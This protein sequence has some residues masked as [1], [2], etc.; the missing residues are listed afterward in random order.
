M[1][2]QELAWSWL[3]HAAVL[4]AVILGAGCLV[5]CLCGEPVKRIRLIQ[6][7]FLAGVLAVLLTP[8]SIW[9]RWSLGLW[10]SVS[11]QPA[12]VPVEVFHEAEA[13]PSPIPHSQDRPSP[14]DKSATTATKDPPRNVETVS[15]VETFAGPEV[16]DESRP[17]PAEGERVW[18]WSIPWARLAV[19]GYLT[20]AAALLCWW[21]L[22]VLRMVWLNRSTQPA[23]RW[24]AE[25]LRAIAGDGGARVR[26]RCGD[27]V[28]SPMV[29]GG[30]RPV[31]L[32]PQYLCDGGN[33][34]ELRF[35]LAHEW[36]HIENRDVWSWQLASFVAFLFY[37]QPAYWWLRRQLRLC[38]DYLAD[39]RAA[40]Q[41]PVP[42][43]YAEF[44]VG[45]AR[46]R[47]SVPAAALGIGDGRSNLYRRVVMLL[48]TRKA[49]A[50]GCHWGWNLGVALSALALLA[51]LSTVRLDAADEAHQAVRDSDKPKESSADGA[52]IK[53][54][55]YTGKVSDKDTG[56]PIEGAMVVVRRS[57]Y[58][59]GMENKIMQESKHTT[60]KDG[61]Y[62]FT[63]PP[64]QV[65]ERS[66]YIELDVE[67]PDY[68][69]Q[70]NFGY[71]L[72]M[73]LKDEKLGGRPFFE[74]VELRPGKAVT[75]RLE[76]PDGKPAVGVK[77]LSY[78]I[79]DKTQE[80]VFEYG[81]FADTKTNEKGEFRV[82]MVTP[83]DAVLW[84]LPA[85]GYVPST[86]VVGAK[87]GDLG[88][89]GLKDGIRIKGTV[90]DAQGKPLAGISV[91]AERER[92]ETT[93]EFFQSHPVAD[94]ISRTARSNDKGEF[95]MEPLPP[96]SYR[97]KPD[98]QARDGSSDR[99]DW[100][101]VPLG[102]VF[103]DHKLM[104]KE[105]EKPEA[106]EVRAVPHVVIEAQF[107]DSMGKTRGGHE[108]F[109]FGTIDKKNF[110]SQC[111]ITEKGKVTALVPHGLE[112]VRMQLSTNEHS[113]LRWRMSKEGKLN[114]SHEIDLGTLNKDVSG[115]E[116]IRYEA[117]IALVKVTA[118]DG[119]KLKK[120]GVGIRY[121]AEK[122]ER[123]GRFLG[124]AGLVQSDVF[125]ED[126]E[127]GRFRSSQLLPDDEFEIVAKAEG[128]KEATIEKQKLA[129]GVTKEY[130]LVLEKE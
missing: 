39:A 113:A 53:S 71:A 55:D 122:K 128:Y 112:Q 46:R 91:N 87:R 83:G 109:V 85:K 123:N 19:G 89:F 110:F 51:L 35:C 126:Q 76:T 78:S 9:P 47:L 73:I 2:W 52:E 67:H 14:T 108:P 90:L 80:G 65:K 16:A 3:V 70:K 31:I 50:H 94:Q 61:K 21:L 95:E 44:L 30:W 25:L 82:V 6:W 118:K 5:V 49:L 116:I 17:S 45:L 28:A 37:Y 69:P 101:A 97:V 92:G 36:S 20:G 74:S 107:Y 106:I 24:V 72:G 127:D 48:K 56:K 34:A 100:A 43:D 117:P 33:V 105:G 93:N 60:D 38:Q 104:L 7:T 4:S 29:S 27:R 8:L 119:A 96:G 22:G 15:K 32:L 114:S 42:E 59:S 18:T 120:V 58:K 62:H 26:L 115:I 54:I 23:P 81:S 125:F 41:G 57:I 64:E 12:V 68:A 77:V 86:H 99:K 84:I 103:L 13:A 75:G 129:E 88:L 11:D 10:R 102:A 63:I 130:E 124:P 111:Q 66:L 98:Q 79:T 40:Q 1:A 121:T